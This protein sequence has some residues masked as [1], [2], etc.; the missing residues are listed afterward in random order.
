MR[1]SIQTKCWRNLLSEGG[2][3]RLEVRFLNRTRNP[4]V[5]YATNTNIVTATTSTKVRILAQWKCIVRVWNRGNSN[6]RL[7]LLTTPFSTKIRWTESNKCFVSSD[8][9]LFSQ[10]T[11]GWNPTTIRLHFRETK[12]KRI[13]RNRT[14]SLE[15]IN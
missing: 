12:G 14:R 2:F 3:S 11:N 1:R 15:H 8:R 13:V 9:V 5:S 4:N 10:V 7:D 6:P